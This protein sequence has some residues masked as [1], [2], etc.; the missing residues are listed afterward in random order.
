MFAELV[1]HALA[2]FERLGVVREREQA[3]ELRATLG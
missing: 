1:E 2:V 3:A